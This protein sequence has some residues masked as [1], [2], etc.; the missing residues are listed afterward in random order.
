VTEYV[1]AA[2]RVWAE[3]KAKANR[4][5]GAL[6][7]PF[8][9]AKN[10]TR[11]QRNRVDW[12]VIH[13]AETGE[14]PTVAEAL[15]SWCAGPHAPEASWHYAVDSDSITQSVRDDMVA[16]HAPGANDYGIGIELGGRAN[17]T[18]EQWLDEYGQKMLVLAARLVGYLSV[19][20]DIPLEFVDVD[21]LKAGKRGITTHRAVTYAWRQ[22]THIDPG[23]HFPMDVLLAKAAEF[24]P[25]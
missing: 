14:F 16:W 11:R 23:A 8:R 3:E 24:M 12:I 1:L 7:I 13:S 25:Q 5:L 17:Q 10:Y 22:S 2:A 20:W 6:D 18:R 15:Q 9:E 19:K 4:E 21:G